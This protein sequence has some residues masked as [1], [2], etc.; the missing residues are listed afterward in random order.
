M[1]GRLAFS[2]KDP[3]EVQSGQTG[4]GATEVRASRKEGDGT[5]PVEDA[6]RACFPGRGATVEGRQ[7]IHGLLRRP[8]DENA[9]RSDT[10]SRGASAVATRQGR[11]VAAPRRCHVFAVQNAVQIEHTP[12]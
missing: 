11:W 8:T 12:P 3:Q 10:G 5:G 6:R 1:R 9:S 7:A 2:G 4:N